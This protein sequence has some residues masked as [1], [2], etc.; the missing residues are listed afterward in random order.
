[1]SQ[2]SSGE[3]PDMSQM[4]SGE[5]PD[6]SQMGSGEMPNMSQMS[7]GEMPDMSQM[8]SDDTSDSTQKSSDMSGMSQR[9]GGKTGGRETV[10][11]Y[12]PVAVTVHTG[13][14]STATFSILEAGD[15]L[16]VLFETKEDGSEVIT[17]IWMEGSG[18]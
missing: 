1:M 18:G 9:S 3:M 4:S 13:K 8:S 15:E 7:S 16:T 6:M 14:T 11:V 12:L 5:M 17:E 10:T 2:M